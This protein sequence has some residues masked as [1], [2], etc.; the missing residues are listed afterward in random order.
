MAVKKPIFEDLV[1]MTAMVDIV[2]FLLIFFV[3][4]SMQGT[5]SS[6][7]MPAPDS[8]S[9]TKTGRKSISDV[10]RDQDTVIVRIDHDNAVWL[11]DTEIP[12]GSSC[13][14]ELRVRLRKE[15]EGSASKN[16]LLVLGNSECMH[17]TVVM[18]LDAGSDSGFD[19]AQLALDDES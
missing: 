13:E 9:V 7:K 2:F 6:I 1:D 3:V 4:T 17:G 16:K 18:V 12:G 15:R 5:F 10:E 19:D 11:N 8:D 14:N